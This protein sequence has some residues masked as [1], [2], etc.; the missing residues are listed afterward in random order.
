MAVSKVSANGFVR[1]AEFRSQSNPALWYI[2]A[3]RNLKDGV[4]QVSCSCPGWRFHKANGADGHKPPCRHLKAFLS[5]VAA[6]A[7]VQL[8]KEGADWYLERTGRLAR[9]TGT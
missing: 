6:T 9:M 2:V 4:E 7:D 3:K 1:L 8:T 5:G